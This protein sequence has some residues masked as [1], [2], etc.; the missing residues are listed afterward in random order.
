VQDW[1]ITQARAAYSTAH[2]GHGYF[3][4]GP[5]GHIQV[6]PRPGRDATRID[7]HRITDRLEADGLS[8]PVLV[9]FTDILQASKLTACRYRS[10]CASPTSSRIGSNGCERPLTAR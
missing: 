4:I 6:T 5:E 3:D 10:W 1:D 2:W 7:L 9:R 8:L